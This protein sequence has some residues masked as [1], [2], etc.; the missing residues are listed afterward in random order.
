[1][2]Q[3]LQSISAK[4]PVEF[5]RRKPKQGKRTAAKLWYVSIVLDLQENKNNNRKL[6]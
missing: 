2:N 1:M 6:M 4:Y 3:S 5:S